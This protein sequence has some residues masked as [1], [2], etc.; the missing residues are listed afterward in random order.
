[1][2]LVRQSWADRLLLHLRYARVY[3]EIQTGVRQE[4][5][6]GERHRHG[7]S[8]TPTLE[9]AKTGMLEGRMD[10]RATASYTRSASTLVDTSE[11]RYN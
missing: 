2:G 10:V 4:I 9:Y 6:F 1:M 11:Y 3:K 7:Y 8:L 5:V